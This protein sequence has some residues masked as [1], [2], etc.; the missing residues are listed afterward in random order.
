MRATKKNHRHVLITGGAGF[1]GSHLARQLLES[2]HRVTS[3]DDLSTGN[4]ANVRSLIDHSCFRLVIGNI[5]NKTVLNRLVAEC[6]EIYHLAATVG[7]ELVVKDPIQAIQNNI[8]GTEHVF[9]LAAHY[10]RKIFTASSSEIYGKTAKIPFRETDDCVYGPTHNARWSYAY[11]KAIDEFMAL[12]L[13]RNRHLPVIVGRLFNTVGPRQTG[14][15][16]MVIPRLMRQALQGKPMT[17]YGDG[18]QTRCFAYVGEVVRVMAML[19]ETPKAEG[20]IFNIGSTQEISMNKLAEKIRR[21][22]RSQS[23]IVHIPYDRAYDAGFEDMRRRVPD[24]HKLRR[25]IGCAPRLTIDQ[26]LDRILLAT[27]KQ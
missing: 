18:R 24:V 19:M 23:P 25:T 12:A 7:V 3:I 10:Q 1:I 5:M 13:W 26:I 2:G 4:R 15:Y 8:N 20:E 16:G 6:D 21:K 11:A 14:R 27:S 22:T 17:V 9:E